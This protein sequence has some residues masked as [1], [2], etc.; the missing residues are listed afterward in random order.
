MKLEIMGVDYHIEIL[1]EDKEQTLVFLHGFTGSTVTWHNIAPQFSEYRI[2]LIDLLGHGLTASPVNTDRYAMDL[3]L[4][5]LELLFDRMGLQDFALAGYSM[6]GRVALAYACTYSGRL[7]ALILESA[8]PGLIAHQQQ[9]E[10]RKNDQVLAVC[11][12]RDGID[13]FVDSW[14]KIPLFESQQTLPDE[15]KAAVRQERLAQDATG[16]SNSLIGMGTGA[17]DS[18]W[19]AIGQ[20]DLPVL[21]M[22]GKFDEKFTAIAEE[23][24]S[25]MPNAEHRKIFGGHALHVE[26]PAEFATMVGEYLKLNYLGGKS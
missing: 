2:V 15:V 18:Y 14:E 22:T 13:S 1:N 23:M 20:L 16:L 8:S 7:S 4:Q 9:S 6:G 26:K 5:D 17:Q 25:L 12:T 24:E 11:I 3:Q 21:L 10:R 19:D